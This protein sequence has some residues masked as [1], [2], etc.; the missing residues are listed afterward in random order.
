MRLSKQI[1]TLSS[2]TFLVILVVGG[3]YFLIF[4]NGS[5]KKT[6]VEKDPSE[7]E[8]S[9]LKRMLPSKAPE[10]KK[11][12]A[13]SEESAISAALTP[14]G[15]FI[16]YYSKS[17]QAFEL[18]FFTGEKK[19][20]SS[21]E[22][23]GIIDALWSPDTTKAFS[24]FSKGEKTVFS[25]YD[26]IQ[27]KGTALNENIVSVAWQGSGKIIYAYFGPDGKNGSLNISDPDGSDW[28]KITDLSE[29]NIVIA[30]VPMSGTVS[31]WKKPDA[32][33]ETLLQTSSIINGEKKDLTKGFFGA[34]FLWSPDGTM[35]LESNI[36]KKGGSK[37][38]L[39]IMDDSGKNYRSLNIPTLVSKCAW[40]KDSRFI[41]YAQPTSIP[42]NAAMPNDYA[43][44]KFTT[45]DTFWKV[46]VK[47]GEKTRLIE[48]AELEKLGSNHDATSLFLNSNESQ[49]FFINRIDGKLYKLAL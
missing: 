29:K 40:S 35:I 27:G 49:L 1:F 48:L 25:L 6:V 34:D 31:F 17:G 47:T 2:I 13:I 32:N 28:N 15:Q 3:V 12:E 9:L 7:K 30:P 21:Y 43:N 10:E 42:E 8:D 24:K 16:R 5:A 26:Y 46:D 23:P 4:D 22:L 44:K 33:S 41:Y 36:D 14:D 39:G 11:I 19:T 37:I 20:L 38:Q 45:N 18:D